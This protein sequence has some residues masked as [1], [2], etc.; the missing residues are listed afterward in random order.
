MHFF[1]TFGALSFLLGFVFVMKLVW[2]KIDAVYFSKLPVQREVVDQP[3]FFIA[4]GAV[5]IGVQLFLTGF[6]AEMMMMKKT[7]KEEYLVIDKKAL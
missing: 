7:D 6:L 3:L 5:V 4:L 2:D 1:G